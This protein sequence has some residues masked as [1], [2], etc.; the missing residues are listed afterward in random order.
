MRSQKF[1]WLPVLITVCAM[2]VMAQI[3]RE[4]TDQS[5]P[6]RSDPTKRTNTQTETQ[7]MHVPRELRCRGGASLEF[8][9][10]FNVRQTGAGQPIDWLT[11]TFVW[12]KG[13]AGMLGEGLQPGE[14]SWVNYARDTTDTQRVVSIYIVDRAEPRPKLNG[15]EVVLGG[16]AA[17]TI[18]DADTVPRYLSDSDHYWSFW[19]TPKDNGYFDVHRHSY[20]KKARVDRIPTQTVPM[21]RHLPPKPA[22][23][24]RGSNS[25]EHDTSA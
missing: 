25:R 3:R 16:E 11:I 6:I 1:I 20:W 21:K 5:F 23:M 2:T 4:P 24:F 12:A 13:P 22:P 10:R 8:Y 9:S 14:C 19:V 17:E 15:R 18:T 7:P